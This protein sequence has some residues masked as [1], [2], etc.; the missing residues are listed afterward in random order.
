MVYKL[1]PAIISISHSDIKPNKT[2]VE[3][4]NKSKARA[5]QMAIKNYEELINTESADGWIFEREITIEYLWDNSVNHSA[6]LLLFYKNDLP[7]KTT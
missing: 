4:H 3:N 6:P 5:E 7:Q 1:K 2:T